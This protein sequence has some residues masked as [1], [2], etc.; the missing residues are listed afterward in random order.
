MAIKIHQYYTSFTVNCDMTNEVQAEK[1]RRVA[2]GYDGRVQGVGFRFTTVEIARHHEVTGYV[3]N[4]MDGSVKL[5]AEG[6]DEEL[7]KLLRDIR[8]AHIFRYVIKED[9]NWSDAT[10]EYDS[11]TVRYS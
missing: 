6:L 3:Q 2:V 11:F 8:A 4:M 9:I 7:N 10:G 1:P 5:V